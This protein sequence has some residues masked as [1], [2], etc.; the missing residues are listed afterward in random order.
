M[1]LK[2]EM[3][4]QTCGPFVNEY[5]AR[6][7]IMCALGCGADSDG[8]TDLDYVHEKQVKIL[9]IFAAI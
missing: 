8:K 9:L 7:L 4:G 1:A 6:D 2:L 3:Q 5:T